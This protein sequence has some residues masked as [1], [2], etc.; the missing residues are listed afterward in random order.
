MRCRAYTALIFLAFSGYA[1]AP[2]AVGGDQAAGIF[3]GLTKYFN[4]Y[5]ATPS[6]GCV[7]GSTGYCVGTRPIGDTFFFSAWF[8]DASLLPVTGGL[9][10]V[11]TLNDA[12]FDALCGSFTSRNIIVSQLDTWSWAT[13]TASHMTGI[14]CMDSYGSGGA[15]NSPSG[16]TG[17]LTS[18]DSSGLIGT[19]KSRTPFVRSGILYL[20][21]ERQIQTGAPSVHD[22][23][24]IMS[25]D[26]GLHWCN[27]YTLYNVGTS[28]G[29]CNSSKW[30]ADGDAPKC[31]N[32]GTASNPCTDTGYTDSTHPSIMWKAMGF[33]TENWYWVNYG[34]QDGATPP[35]PNDGSDPSTYDYFM[36]VDGSIARVAKASNLLDIASWE[37]YTCATLIPSAHCDL[38]D[39][40]SWTGTYASRT[41][42]FFFSYY[43]SQWDNTFIFPWSITY[44]KEF[45]SYIKTG[46][47]KIGNPNL[48]FEISSG[49]SLVGPW[50]LV[51]SSPAQS[52]AALWASFFSPSPA[53]GYTV[54]SSDPPHIRLTTTSNNYQGASGTALFEEWDL[55]L[56]YLE[57][58]G[59]PRSENVYRYTSGAGYQFSPGGGI[60]GTFPSDGLVWSF[61]FL[62]QGAYSGITDWPYFTDRGTQSAAI[63]PCTG[64]AASPTACGKMNPGQGAGMGDYGIYTANTG[65]GGH[66]RTWVT[67]WAFTEQNVPSGMSGNGTFSVVSVIKQPSSVAPVRTSIWS[68]GDTSATNTALG[69]NWYSGS[70]LPSVEWW[71]SGSAIWYMQPATSPYSLDNWYFIT[72]TV[73]A[74][75][76]TPA[77]HCWT[78]LSGVLTDFCAGLTRTQYLTG[79]TQTPNT[80]AGPLML[81]I[82]PGLGTDTASVQ[83]ATTMVY[84]RALTQIEVQRI[85]T[86]MKAKMAARG[87]TVQ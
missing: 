5:D 73:Q 33:G 52:S 85:Y 69:L 18:S 49:P 48:A 20:P 70:L 64:T 54:V 24:M 16:W 77:T 45:K 10:V 80:T 46:A 65:Y 60:N 68:T 72:I 29:V 78:G 57:N 31:A 75:G 2:I 55:V 84:D 87:V 42:T 14:N 47:V 74:N 27:P 4:W 61:D 44:L 71:G 79:A 36:S 58:G 59:K 56:G 22:S 13:P 63:I 23:T 21:V 35:T 40:G 17:A 28:P 8:A 38:S 6:G 82:G 41:P 12:S 34:N 19:W 11:H 15:S 7:D 43:G 3:P 81:G 51:S 76:S 66:Y 25:P 83:Q 37:Y 39:A 53:L 50:T 62:D 9:P 67:G 26:G 1:Q 32:G 86:A 30:Q